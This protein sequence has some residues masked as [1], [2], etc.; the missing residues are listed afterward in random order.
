MMPVHRCVIG[1][2][3]PHG[4]KEPRP[5][6]GLLKLPASICAAGSLMG[7]AHADATNHASIPHVATKRLLNIPRLLPERTQNLSISW[8]RSGRAEST[9]NSL[10]KDYP[11]LPGTRTKGSFRG[12]LTEFLQDRKSV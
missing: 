12:F 2:R 4:L 11:R 9:E 10:S 1:S 6:S 7:P 5:V 3:S 8:L